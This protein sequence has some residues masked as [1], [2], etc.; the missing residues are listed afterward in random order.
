MLNSRREKM[1]LSMFKVPSIRFSGKH[2]E[3]STSSFIKE[4]DINVNQ[5][6]KNTFRTQSYTDICTKVQTHIQFNVEPSSASIHDRYIHLCDILLEPQSETL[7][8]LT[9]T[10]S[11]HPLLID[12][13]KASLNSWMICEQLLESIHQV[14]TNHQKVKQIIKLAQIRV[15]YGTKIY[16]ELASYSSLANPLSEFGP[17]KFPTLLIDHKLLLKKLTTKHKR[18]KRKRKIINFF[19][20]AGGCAL[21]ASYAALAVALLVLACHG[22][23]VTVA[24]PGL[25][26]CLLGLIKKTNLA[27]KNVKPSE[28]KRVG[29]QLDVAAKGVY[30]MIKD[31]D[32]MGWLVRRLHNEVEFGKAMARKCFRTRKADV[33]EELMRE[34][35]VHESCLLEQLE[36]LEDHIY[37]CLLNVN[38]SRKLLV[39]EIIHIS[40]N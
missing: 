14:N 8:N 15:P 30:T 2:D 11:L 38:R 40:E 26:V 6:Y 25:I 10:I 21:I 4:T 7:D 9:N 35:R 19:K 37:L 1:K 20:R 27:K 18:I 22:L 32:T 29:A 17:Q 12:F 39:D 3:E 16:E 31:L 5:E 36:E 33:L 23:V 13:F 34:F 28:L 24:S